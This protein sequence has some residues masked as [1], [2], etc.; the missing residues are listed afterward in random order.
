MEKLRT[1][2]ALAAIAS[3]GDPGVFNVLNKKKEDFLYGLGVYNLHGWTADGP[4]NRHDFATYMRRQEKKVTDYVD[5]LFYMAIN[6]TGKKINSDGQTNIVFVFNPL[7][8]ERN[9]LVDIPVGNDFNSVRD[10]ENRQLYPGYTILI[11]EKK[12]LRVWVEG[13]PSVGYKLFQLDNKSNMPDRGPFSFSNNILETPLYRVRFSKSGA[14]FS[15]FD[16]KMKKEW[17][18]G[19][20]NDPGSTNHDNG[21]KIRIIERDQKQIKLLCCSSDPVKHESIVTFYADDPRIDFQNTILQNFDGPLYWSFGFNVDDP[22][23]WHE[24]VGAVIKAKTVSS[25]GHYADRMARY[26]HLSLNHFLNVGNRNSSIT[27]S[28]S[29][30]LF[31]R[32]GN[33]TPSFLDENSST[34]HI[35]AGGQ[36]NENL[37]MIKQ[38]GDT[39]FHQNFSL[40]PHNI[41]FNAGMSMRFSLEHQNP[42]VAGKAFSEGSISDKRYS[43]IKNDNKDVILWTLKP[44]EEDGIILRFW[45]MGNQPVTTDIL[46]NNSIQKA[47]YSSHVE[48][49]IKELPVSG[50]ILSVD[51]NQQQIKTFRVLLNKK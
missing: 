29:D 7:S 24:E 2:E 3:D 31:F 49:D 48:T 25:G 32:L 8:W 37:G 23:V 6:E 40:L 35:L 22:E 18:R 11:G 50:N 12:F 47:F 21:D 20:L 4:V 19:M 28:N 5:T 9:G 13:I 30:C 27:L 51:L 26:D 14:I 36:I 43:F 45:N 16:K 10:L 1:A 17:T 33:S 44:G 38:D 39:L 42:M 46:I 41:E 34:V 15:L